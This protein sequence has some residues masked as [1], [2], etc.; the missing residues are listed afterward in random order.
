M[1]AP[2]S[3]MARPNA[4]Q[5]S[6]KQA[7]AADEHDNAHGAQ[8]RGAIDQKGI[9][10]GGPHIDHHPVYE[11]YDNRPTEHP[12]RAMTIAVGVNNMPNDPGG[13]ERERSR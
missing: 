11:G 8:T 7:F 5:K 10:V 4:A 6:R 1:I 9:A 2:T 3:A 12:L 13:P